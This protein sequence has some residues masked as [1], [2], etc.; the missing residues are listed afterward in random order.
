MHI[1]LDAGQVF[2]RTGRKQLLLAVGHIGLLVEEVVIAH[3]STERWQQ[4]VGHT[5]GEQAGDVAGGIDAVVVG[6]EAG[7]ID[8]RV[9]LHIQVGIEFIL[10]ADVQ[11]VP[12]EVQADDGRQSPAL[13]VAIQLL[14]CGSFGQFGKQRLLRLVSYHAC[15]RLESIRGRYHGF[16]T[17][18]VNLN[19]TQVACVVV[20]HI[21]HAT[22]Q[23]SGE[24]IIYLIGD[25]QL[26][27]V[28]ELAALHVAVHVVAVDAHALS[29]D[30]QHGD[31]GLE[32]G[33]ALVERSLTAT[34][35]HGKTAREYPVAVLVGRLEAGNDG[36]R[37]LALEELGGIAP[38]LHAIGKGSEGGSYLT[39][40]IG[41]L[42]VQRQ[43]Q[44]I[45]ALDEGQTG[46]IGVNSIDTGRSITRQHA[47]E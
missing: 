4:V 44:A 19:V 6:G 7:C 13:L 45:T 47:Q 41:T 33:Q 5:D 34:T 10:H 27:A 32:R 36:S 20:A 39:C 37:S 9:V 30:G 26:N 8:T 23:E 43:M 38:V 22:T 11:T 21:V 25:A 16:R 40:L 28:E 24:V 14:I 18:H 1:P 42:N 3:R 12:V 17:R 29:E 46:R 2:V 31:D 35:C 15:H